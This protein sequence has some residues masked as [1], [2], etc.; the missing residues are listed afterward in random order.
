MG[1]QGTI[2]P[3]KERQKRIAKPVQKAKPIVLK[4]MGILIF[5]A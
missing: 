5:A 2:S 1:L 3:G 4:F